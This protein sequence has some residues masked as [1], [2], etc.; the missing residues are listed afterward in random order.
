M[1]SK[2]YLGF[3]GLFDGVGVGVNP[4]SINSIADGIIDLTNN[5]EYFKQYIRELSDAGEFKV[6]N[7]EFIGNKYVEDIHEII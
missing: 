5:G 4:R 6:F 1:F 2:G 3:D 7:S